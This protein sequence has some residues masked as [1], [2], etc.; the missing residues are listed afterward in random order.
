MLSIYGTTQ[1][2]SR[3]ATGEFTLLVDRQL[4]G[5]WDAFLEYAGDFPQRGG[6]RHLLHFGTA[7]KLAPR[8]QLD[9][10]WGL[11]LSSAAPD[12]FVAVGY[13][14]LFQAVRRL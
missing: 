12:H 9:F 5:P 2:G 8:H 13:S 10:H 7:Y 3:N 14:F 4:T 1:G 11:G 6:P